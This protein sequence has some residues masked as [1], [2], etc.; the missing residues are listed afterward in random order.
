VWNHPCKF[1]FYCSYVFW[2]KNGDII[3]AP[4]LIYIVVVSRVQMSSWRQAIR[5]E[6]FFVSHG[7]CS[8]IPSLYVPLHSYS[9]PSRS[10][11]LNIVSIW[12][13]H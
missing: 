2:K 1:N 13:C 12:K 10:L 9:F 6:C 7:R 11:R 3:F 8:R 5:T 4:P